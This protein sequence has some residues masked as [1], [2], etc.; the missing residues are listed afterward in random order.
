MIPRFGHV[1]DSH[2]TRSLDKRWGDVAGAITAGPIDD[3]RKWAAPVMQQLAQNCCSHAVRNAAYATAK[4]A[5][6]PIELPSCL[7]L[8]A[9]AMLMA[10]TKPPL[11]DQG[12]SLRAMLA[13][14]A[15]VGLVAET[16]WPEVD[17]NLCVVPPA[18]VFEH[19]EA[20]VLLN[21]YTI[22]P[23]PHFTDGIISALQRGRFPAIAMP[24]DDAFA[25]MA[26][27]IYEATGGAMLGYHAMCVLGWSS[28]TDAFLVQNSWGENFGDRGFV[29]VD[30]KLLG[31]IATDCV[32]IDVVPESAT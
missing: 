25:A 16:R 22:D 20:A 1:P 15:T 26:D 5:G 24:V 14:T 27:G 31:A 19:G 18:D 10:G 3:G 11:P 4:R 17:E 7:A 2:A 23:G 32:V 13:W 28:M 29:C 21:W 6:R 9:G 30:R 8:Y 12:S